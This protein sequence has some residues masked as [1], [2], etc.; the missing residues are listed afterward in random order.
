MYENKKIEMSD[1]LLFTDAT[2]ASLT[3]LLLTTKSVEHL[4]TFDASFA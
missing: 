1:L 3:T 2:L 4:A